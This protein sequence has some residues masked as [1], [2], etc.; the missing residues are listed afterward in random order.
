MKAKKALDRA[1]SDQ[2]KTPEFNWSWDEWKWVVLIAA[3]L[4]VGTGG[5]MYMQKRKA[6]QEEAEKAK[7]TPALPVM[8]D[9]TPEQRGAELAGQYLIQSGC[10]LEWK[11]GQGPIAIVGHV[12]DFIVPG[13]EWA[14]AKGIT[15]VNNLTT[16]LYGL[17]MPGC[18]MPKNLEAFDLDKAVAR[19]LSV[20]SQTAFDMWR[21]YMPSVQLY[22]TL[23]GLVIAQGGAK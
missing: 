6:K 11:P 5:I 15:G 16:A 7:P 20:A 2:S 21:A 9:Q 23:R 22:L 12:P 13:L 10:G 18:G 8:Q 1:T 14:R 4:G 17:L 3:I 19:Q